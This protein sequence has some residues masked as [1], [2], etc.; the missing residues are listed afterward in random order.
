M[1]IRRVHHITIAVR[2]LAKAS[3][4]F[5]EL[6]GAPGGEASVVEAFGIKS[7]DADLAGLAVQYVAPNDAD[8]ALTRFIER[9]GEGLY[10][11]A[12][13]VDDLAAAV[14]EL[15]GRGI[16]VSDPVDA[17]PGMRSAFV[18][19]AATHGVSV[20]LVEVSDVRDQRSELTP[21]PGS[22][23]PEAGGETAA[24]GATPKPIRDLR[25]DE[26]EEWSDTD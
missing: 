19:M 3:E 23:A 11:I 21:E 10:N 22:Q 8:S 14:A 20:Q 16:R 15:R 17:P 5:S 2:D 12:L 7:A 9:R 1:R 18:A 6:F 24:D 25:P 4:T 26:W 13:E